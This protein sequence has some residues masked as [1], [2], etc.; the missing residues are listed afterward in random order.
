MEALF[1]DW[2]IDNS[3][4]CLLFSSEQVVVKF[5]SGLLRDGGQALEEVAKM[6]VALLTVCE[7]LGNNMNEGLVKILDFTFSVLPRT[8]KEKMLLISLF[9]REI[10]ERLEFGDLQ[11]RK[12]VITFNSW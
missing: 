10:V 3:A 7:A 9:W 8:E 11:V 12:F 2:D 1:Q 5:L 4:A 6:M